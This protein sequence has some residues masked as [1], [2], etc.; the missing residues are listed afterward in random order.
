LRGLEGVPDAAGEELLERDPRLDHA[1]GRDARLGDPQVQGHVR[2]GLGEAAVRL[3][4]LAGVRVLQADD[5]AVE[6]EVVHEPA[7][8]E[9]RLDHGLHVILGVAGLHLGVDAA[10]V[11][12]DAD[13]EVVGPRHLDEEGHLLPH[14]LRLLV[15]PEVARVVADL[16]DVG[17]YDL[18]QAV[19]LL[20]VDHEVGLRLAANVAQRVDVLGAVHGYADEGAS[21]EPDGLGLGDGSVDVLRAC[22]AHALHCDGVTGAQEDR[23]DAD[24]AGGVPLHLDLRS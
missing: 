23:G 21:G 2:A 1:L 4:H 5:V 9:S 14:G 18:G 20:E 3:D 17:G 11:H 19:A 10:A 12:P 7:V 16:V 22:G 8:L 15:V 24:G 13:G 6:P